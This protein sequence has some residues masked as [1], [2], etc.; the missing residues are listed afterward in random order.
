MKTLGITLSLAVLCVTLLAGCK[1]TTACA[2]GT[3]GAKC[4]CKAD[5][6]CPGC[7]ARM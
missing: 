2:C 6:K 1:A 7:Q 5:C 3:P 4:I